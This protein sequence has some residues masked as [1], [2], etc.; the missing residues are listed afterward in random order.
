MNVGID[1]YGEYSSK[2]YGANAMLFTAGNLTVYFSYRTPVAFMYPGKGLTI[3]AN[4]WGSTTGKHLNWIDPDK[5]K[6]IPGPEFE[7]KLQAILKEK[8]LIFD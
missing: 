2:N 4:E 8:N 1:F 3:R 7:E 5:S 6:R